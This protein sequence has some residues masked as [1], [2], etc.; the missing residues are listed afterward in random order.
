[1][2]HKSL[3]HVSFVLPR[4]QKYCFNISLFLR[5]FQGNLRY[6]LVV[7]LSVYIGFAVDAAM[8]A[9]KE[10][11]SF[12]SCCSA[13]TEILLHSCSLSEIVWRQFRLRLVSFH[14][15]CCSSEHIGFA[16]SWLTTLQFNLLVSYR[17]IASY[18]LSFWDCLKAVCVCWSLL[19]IKNVCLV[20]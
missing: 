13:S 14:F 16:V 5:L 7:Y 1:M 9:T 11:N 20:L 6:T 19:F 18:I 8:N 4:L 15:T 2:Q 17:N 3:T 10:F 12:V